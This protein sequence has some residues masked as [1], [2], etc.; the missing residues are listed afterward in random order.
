M[1]K[2]N[3]CSQVTYDLVRD[4]KPTHNSTGTVNAVGGP[5]VGNGETLGE[6]HMA[7]EPSPVHGQHRAHSSATPS[8][9]PLPRVPYA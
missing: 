8:E 6:T 1:K 7:R 2:Y 4:P 3:L 9:L 5:Q